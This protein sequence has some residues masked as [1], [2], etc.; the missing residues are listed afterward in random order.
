MQVVSRPV[1]CSHDVLRLGRASRSCPSN[2]QA[3]ACDP[4]P[5]LRPR[6][7]CHCTHEANAQGDRAR[8]LADVMLRRAGGRPLELPGK[9]SQAGLDGRGRRGR[10]RCPHACSLICTRGHT[11]RAHVPKPLLR[12]ASVRQVA[13]SFGPRVFAC[14]ESRPYLCLG[15]SGMPAKCSCGPR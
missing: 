4:H 6:R 13:D 3:S 15:V 11:G 14:A 7:L 10:D 8:V 12:A 2:E 9:P 5:H 1:R